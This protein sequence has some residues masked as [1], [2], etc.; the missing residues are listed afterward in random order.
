MLYLVDANVLITAHN[1]YYPIDGVPEFWDWLLHQA[2]IGIVKMPFEIYEEIKLGGKD[3]QKDML[4]NWVADGAVKKALLL[5]ENVSA[6]L[7]SKCT[8]DGYAP[9]LTDSELLQ[10]GR[11]P[12][13][14]AYAMVSPKDRC[15]VSNEV[16]APSKTRHK[17]KIPDVCTT[18]GVQCYNIFQMMRMLGFK[19]GWKK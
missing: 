3:T 19:T 8:K 14:I 12:F 17:R 11:D 9:D 18:M 15:I 10:I 1:D 6:P 16:S 7:V 2:T 4:Y 5:G 13:L